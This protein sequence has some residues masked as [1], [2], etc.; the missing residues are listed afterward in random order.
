MFEI[1][2]D[3]NPGKQQGF[4]CVGYYE[5]LG[6]LFTELSYQVGLRATWWSI[7]AASGPRLDSAF[8][9]ASI[10]TNKK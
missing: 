5:G 10:G 9:Q 7:A 1:V 8:I 2:R 3:N 4:I 6:K